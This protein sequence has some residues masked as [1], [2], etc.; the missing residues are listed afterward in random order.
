[1]AGKFPEEDKVMTN[2]Q[3]TPFALPDLPGFDRKFFF[4]ASVILVAVITFFT[5][6]H[7]YEPQVLRVPD[8]KNVATW[9]NPKFEQTCIYE[10]M[11][12]AEREQIRTKGIPDDTLVANVF[13]DIASILV[14]LLC[15]IHARRHYGK[16]MAYCF[17]AGSF[18]FP[19]LQESIS[20]LFGR[21]TG[22]SA[23][24]GLGEEVFGTYWFTKGGLWF[25]ETPVAMCFGWFYVAYG[26][27]W[28]AGKA[29]PNSSL[30]VRATAGGLLAMIVD[31]WQDPV[32]TSPELMSWVWATGD[33]IRIFGIPQ[34]NFVGWFLLIFIFAIL[35]ELLPDW[36]RR[37]GRAKATAVFFPVLI[38][39][40]FAILAFMVPWC[41]VV[42]SILVLMGFDHALQ[43]PPGW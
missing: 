5:Y 42:R 16:W 13:L 22:M 26:C 43:I 34:T 9:V 20:I 28:M 27:V 40:D 6:L 36:E 24:E 10:R 39:A 19:G 8:N 31:L 2:E 30:M 21:F 23:M 38:L 14:A 35:W 32:A 37:W 4:W 18:I 1:M 29:F 11:T 12:P 25:F 7:H 17:L 3:K 15:Y 33:I 41:F